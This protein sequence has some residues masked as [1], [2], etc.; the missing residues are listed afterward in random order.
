MLLVITPLFALLAHCS[1]Q[2]N[3]DAAGA[4][5]EMQNYAPDQATVAPMPVFSKFDFEVLD[6]LFKGVCLDEKYKDY[7]NATINDQARWI[8]A[9]ALENGPRGASFIYLYDL[10]KSRYGMDE[11]AAV[12]AYALLAKLFVPHYIAFLRY[13]SN[14]N[15]LIFDWYFRYTDDSFMQ[16]ALE[17]AMHFDTAAHQKQIALTESAAQNNVVNDAA[18]QNFWGFPPLKSELATPDSTGVSYPLVPEHVAQYNFAPNAN[19]DV[20]YDSKVYFDISAQQHSNQDVPPP[21]YV[22]VGVSPQQ[23]VQKPLAGPSTSYPSHA[24][25]SHAYATNAA[26][27]SGQPAQPS[28]VFDAVPNTAV[29]YALPEYKEA[30]QNLGNGSAMAVYPD[31]FSPPETSD[32]KLNQFNLA[33]LAIS[34]EQAGPSTSHQNQGGEYSLTSGSRRAAQSGG[35]SA[36]QAGPSTSRQSQGDEY[37]L[38]SGSRRILQPGRRQTQQASTS[39]Q[40]QD[41]T[42]EDE[43]EILPTTSKRAT[44][45]N[46]AGA[47]LEQSDSVPQAPKAKR[48]TKASNANTVPDQDGS[49]PQ[50]EQVVPVVIDD[51]ELAKWDWASVPDDNIK[52]ELISYA[53]DPN[54]WTPR[55]FNYKT[56]KFED[57]VYPK[58]IGYLE[59]EAE[60]RPVEW[61]REDAL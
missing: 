3:G 22:D 48:Q 17:I 44:K 27:V 40:F 25:S 42:M 38:T 52:H 5:I 12:P 4:F 23:F 20:A 57:D 15:R 29:D 37:S 6:Y 7:R 55:R 58:V 9:A 21:D 45:R 1:N 32:S 10:I 50:E 47:A 26:A 19:T 54:G 59:R 60:N 51:A 33:D 16:L 61:R 24:G 35:Y 30:N 28:Y 14:E 31:Y 8:I 18:Q 36:Q 39:A 49:V 56:L 41:L 34:P 53:K 43:I 2:G 11:H 46:N 13:Y